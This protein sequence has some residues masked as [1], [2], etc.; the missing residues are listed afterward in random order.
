MLDDNAFSS[1]NY[2]C[3]WDLYFM[4]KMNKFLVFVVSGFNVS[5]RMIS[6]HF[7][8]PKPSLLLAVSFAIFNLDWAEQ[9]FLKSSL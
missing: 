4:E 6:T 2:S 3:C 5:C 8:N 1:A 7:F 9:L